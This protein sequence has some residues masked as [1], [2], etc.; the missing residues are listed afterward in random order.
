ML[1]TGLS[2]SLGDGTCHHAFIEMPTTINAQATTPLTR[3]HTN[4]P[5]LFFFV[6]STILFSV[7]VLCSPLLLSTLARASVKAF[8]CAGVYIH[9]CVCLVTMVEGCWWG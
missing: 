9:V 1:P 3:I 2:T 4:K 6:S 7:V 8:V 5:K